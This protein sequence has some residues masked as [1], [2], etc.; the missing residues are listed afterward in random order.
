MPT[1]RGSVV[2]PIRRRCRPRPGSTSPRINPNKLNTR[3]PLDLTDTA[4]TADPDSPKILIRTDSAGGTH[5]FAKACRAAGVGYSFG[6]PVIAPVKHAVELLE[7]SNGWYPAINTDG[8]IRDGAWV[9]EATGLVDLSAWPQGTRLILRK[10]RPHPGAQ[11][12][13]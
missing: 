4:R 7:D 10:E 9:A 6:V 13:F 1:L 5:V 12:T 11:L 3:V 8:T 2:G